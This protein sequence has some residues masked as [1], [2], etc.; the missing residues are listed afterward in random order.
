MPCH[1][2]STSTSS[3]RLRTAR[4]TPRKPRKPRKPL[5]VLDL[6]KPGE[7]WAADFLRRS[8]SGP[9]PMWVLLGVR[10]DQDWDH[11]RVA[12][13]WIGPG[14]H[15]VVRISL[16]EQALTWRDF[17]SEGAA[18]EALGEKRGKDPRVGGGT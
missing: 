1:A 11:I 7:R 14:T 3:H 10:R 18:R 9:D 16:T 12:V 6:T 4:K 2:Q 13:R 17:P 8:V 15:S 5:A